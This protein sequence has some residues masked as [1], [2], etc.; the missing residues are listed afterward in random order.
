MRR[1]RRVR[2]SVADHP[3]VERIGFER[4]ERRTGRLE[5]GVKIGRKM[6]NLNM[7]NVGYGDRLPGGWVRR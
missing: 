4:N 3:A 1:V 2:G 5:K 7:M 6:E